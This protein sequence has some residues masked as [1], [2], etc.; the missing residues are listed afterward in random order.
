MS[1][2]K[3]TERLLDFAIILIGRIRGGLA[4]ANVLASMFFGGMT[5]S[6]IADASALGSVEIP[7]MIKAGYDRKFSAAITCASAMVGPL[8]PPSILVVIY[9]LSTSV[10][11]GALFLAGIIPGVL[12]GIALMI[13]SYII[14]RKRKYPI[15]KEKVSLKEFTYSLKRVILPMFLP[16]IIVGGIIS[17]FFTPTEAP[18]VAV[19]YAF[20]VTVFITKTIKFSDLPAMLV[21]S[22]VVT[23]VVMIIVGTATVFGAV[24]SLEQLGDK[25]AALLDFAD[26]IVFLI[27][28]NIFLLVLGTFVDNVPMIL[29]FAPTLAPIAVNLGIH[30]IHFG[31][32]FIIN[33]TLAMI[34]LPLG[35]VLFVACPIAKISMES[36][37][38]KIFLL[39]SLAIGLCINTHQD[40]KC[41]TG[42]PFTLPLF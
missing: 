16:I 11:I 34:T 41:A 7:M 39:Y 3:I 25:I 30:P 27:M 12:V 29:I 28:T 10:S 15:R 18:A 8:I 19:G 24:I 31:M 2:G 5:G 6:A 42:L 22:G 20:I 36:L 4:L 33:C 23:A 9:A 21:R 38:K 40:I 1:H 35:N 37:R 17:G 13:A 26:P 14:S 32:L